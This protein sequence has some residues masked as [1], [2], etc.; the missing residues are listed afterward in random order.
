MNYSGYPVMQ[1]ARDFMYKVYGWMACGLALTGGTAYYVYSNEAIFKYIFSSPLIVIGL[2]IAQIALV[3]SL[4]SMV[5]RMSTTTAALVF[6]GYS[7][8]TGLT[9][10][11]IFYVYQI[12]S[13]YLAFSIAAAMFAVMA[14]YGYFT[15]QDLTSVGSLATMGL[16][17]LIIAML[18]NFFIG[19]AQMDY[20]ISL[21]GVGVFTLLAAY[22]NQ[23]IKQ[24]GQMLLGQGEM[25]NKAALIG[26][27]TLYLDF[28][29]L[30]L[31]LL[32]LFGR[33][34]ED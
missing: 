33:R 18:I 6:I 28:I 30:F 15:K 29:N 9:F 12:E 14:L 16:I 32:R 25:V 22:D 31:F 10:S 8:L 1:S 13:I 19:S 17:G 34:R 7:L 24:M 11:S 20:I 23:K 27:L 4:I 26:A 3:I 2:F 5:G 21:I